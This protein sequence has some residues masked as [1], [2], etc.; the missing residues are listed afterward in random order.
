MCC[1]GVCKDIATDQANC[2]TCG[3]TC[4]QFSARVDRC[5]GGQCRCGA[6]GSI[7][8]SNETCCSGS[9]KNLT[10]DVKNC[11]ACGSVCPGSD[12]PQTTIV[13]CNAAAHT[14]SFGCKGANYNLD[15]NPNNGCEAAD[16]QANHT[17]DSATDM[18]AKGCSDGDIYS[19]FGSIYSDVYNHDPAP[20]GYNS[21]VKA[22][23]LWY[24]VFGTGSGGCANN[25]AIDLFQT[26]GTTSGCYSITIMTDAQSVTI[27]VNGGRASYDMGS[28]SYP[29][30]SWIHF[31]VEKTCQTTRP[32]KADFQVNYHL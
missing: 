5:A 3:F 32:E 9:C 21:T 2:G 14:C 23:P 13:V 28:G 16:T 17:R 12:Y 29:N 8:A 10:T 26:G 22:A 30:N 7:C 4:S 31:R 1:G 11:G 25:P 24:R 20:D 19:F 18:G 15:D 6:S 27:P